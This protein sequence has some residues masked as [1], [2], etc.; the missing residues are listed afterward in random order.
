LGEVP[1]VADAS[2][3]RRLIFGI[4]RRA[5][6]RDPNAIKPIVRALFAMA[7]DGD[8]PNPDAGRCMWSFDDELDLAEQGIHGH[9]DD[10]RRDLVQFL[11]Q[12]G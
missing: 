10:V 11:R 5:M 7:M 2:A 3:R 4:M 1:G 9:K 6:E 8:V 12:H